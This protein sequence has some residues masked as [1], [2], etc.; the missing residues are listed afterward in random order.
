MRP[1]AQSYRNLDGHN[2]VRYG[3]PWYWR[4]VAVLAGI[5]ILGGYVYAW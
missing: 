5:M 1:R 2:A 4:T 3:V